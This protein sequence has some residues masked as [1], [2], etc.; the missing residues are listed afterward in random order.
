VSRCHSKEL[1]L[2]VPNDFTAAHK[3]AFDVVG[4]EMTPKSSY[5]FKFKVSAFFFIIPSLS[6]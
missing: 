2:L 6:N 1:R 5:D 3:L 4:N